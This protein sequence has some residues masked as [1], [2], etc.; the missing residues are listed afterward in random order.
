MPHERVFDKPG[1]AFLLQASVRMTIRQ[2]STGAPCDPRPELRIATLVSYALAIALPASHAFAQDSPSTL[3]PPPA[4][5]PETSSPPA[6]EEPASPPPSNPPPGYEYAKPPPPD[7]GD[8][9]AIVPYTGTGR[10]SSLF[11]KPGRRHTGFFLRLA[12]GAGYTQASADDELGEFRIFGGALSINIA[13]GGA[14]VEN[15]II[16][17]DF[18]SFIAPDPREDIDG[19]TTRVRDD[20]SFSAGGLGLG[21]GG[22]FTPINMFLGGSIALLSVSLDDGGVAVAESD[23]GVGIN[24]V[25][26]KEW[27][28]GP[29]WGLGVAP[30]FLIGWVPDLDGTRL[31]VLGASLMFSATFN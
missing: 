8:I 23:P 25:G 27:W 20:L 31:T 29:E 19:T 13:V 3:E 30:Q 16:Y 4:T 17:A 9:P 7:T 12:V 18:F 11:R 22:Y 21:F 24:I 1:H 26:G 15:F 14:P 28:V 2:L 6:T 10:A 5:T